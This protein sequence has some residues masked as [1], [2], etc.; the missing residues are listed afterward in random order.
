MEKKKAFPVRTIAEV[1]FSLKKTPGKEYVEVF[2]FA[3][4]EG[5]LLRDPMTKIKADDVIIR[6]VIQAFALKEVEWN[7][8]LQPDFR[9]MEI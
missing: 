8:P 7:T 9:E 3:L 2:L 1:R 4:G 6:E 5:I